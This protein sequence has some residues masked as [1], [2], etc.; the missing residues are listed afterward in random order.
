MTS[1]LVNVM[2]ITQAMWRSSVLLLHLKKFIYFIRC[3]EC[4]D[5]FGGGRRGRSSLK[6]TYHA[7]VALWTCL[8][9][10]QKLHSMVQTTYFCTRSLA[11]LGC[12]FPSSLHTPRGLKFSDL[13][14]SIRGKLMSAYLS[15]HASLQT[16]HPCIYW[17]HVKMH[18]S[19]LSLLGPKHHLSQLITPFSL[20][21]FCHLATGISPSPSFSL[22]PW[23]PLLI[24]CCVFL[25][26]LR[27]CFTRASGLCPLPFSLF[28]LPCL[29]KDAIHSDALRAIYMLVTPTRL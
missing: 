4:S 8:V 18:L 1:G 21:H 3:E 10:F 13:Q 7:F 19:V 23:L 6:V 15:F 16:H 5:F 12:V 11:S 29:P 25:S 20:T 17:E 28:H 24:L 26:S 22:L 14:G 27:L 9:L 2:F